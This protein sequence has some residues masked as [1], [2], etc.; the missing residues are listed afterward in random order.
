MGIVAIISQLILGSIT[1]CTASKMEMSYI[2]SQHNLIL[3]YC[4]RDN[5]DNLMSFSLTLVPKK[6]K[7]KEAELCNLHRM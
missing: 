6:K 3:F 1:L 4:P 5:M 7:K 2:P